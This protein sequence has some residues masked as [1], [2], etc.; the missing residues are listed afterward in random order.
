MK[1][2][3]KYIEI[4]EKW[5]KIHSLSGA[6]NKKSIQENIEDS[7]K[8]LE[9]EELKWKEQRLILDVG[10]GN[11]FPAIP[12]AIALEVPFILCEPNA[13]KA[14]FLHHLKIELELNN[15]EVVRSKVQ[16]LNLACK[17][18]LI[19]SRALLGTLDLISL[20]KGVKE[21]TTS[22]LFFKGSKVKE[23]L[24]GLKKY[25]IYNHH[26]RNYLFIQGES[27]CNG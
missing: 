5:N 26:Y 17:P 6:K 27:L 24:E 22:F 2:L 23:E 16:D 20:C 14:A 21:A 9:F 15:V 10:S 18:S 1:K 4:L 13:K 12:L 11:G 8:P 19:T 3:E 7:L 25:K